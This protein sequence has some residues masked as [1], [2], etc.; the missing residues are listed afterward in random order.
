M[1][2]HSHYYDFRKEI[3]MN[4][5]KLTIANGVRIQDLTDNKFK[6]M[7]IS[8]NF[9]LPLKEET[10]GAY[11]LIPS[12]L[13]Q[14]TKDY[15]DISIL[16]KYLSELYGAHLGCSVS[17]IGDYQLINISVGGI[18]DKFALDG[19]DLSLSYT[20][21]V[22][23]CL[24][25]PLVDEDGNFLS[26]NVS[27]E[28][29]QLF[30][31]MDADFSDKRTYS[32]TSCREMMFKGE[33][34]G[35]KRYGSRESLN[36]LKEKDLKSFLELMLKTAKIDIFVL[37]DCNFDKVT[38]FFKNTFDFERSPICT[39]SLVSLCS[40]N[41]KEKVEEEKLAQSKLVMGFKTGAS[42]EEDGDVSRLIS[43]LLGGSASSK[44]FVNVREK[45]SLCYYCSAT[46]DVKKSALFVESGV[47]TEN[48]EKAKSAILKEI[49]DVKNGIFSDEELMFAKLALINAYKSVTDS[50]GSSEGWYLKQI[51]SEKTRTPEEVVRSI[52]EVS[53]ERIIEVSKKIQLDTVFVLKGVLTDE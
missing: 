33:G 8:V 43:V 49:D 52:S 26:D 13:T 15:P 30:E 10:A 29:R 12:L 37:G 20:K 5:D 50:L 22:T 46:P 44:F 53:K 41:Y 9:I 14:V 19:E 36:Q 23:D 25:N 7:K 24:L 32:L 6:T 40:E 16:S 28:K 39:D 17:K 35:I 38:A 27:Q 48:I 34:A 2:N 47:E 3:R 45:L 4:K 11:A 21:L 42:E 18:S 31:T 1:A 51:L